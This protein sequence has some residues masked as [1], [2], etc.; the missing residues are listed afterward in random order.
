MPKLIRN[1][2]S[3][4]Q[5]LEEWQYR[6][7]ERLGILCGAGKPEPWMEKMAEREA[8]AAVAQLVKSRPSQESFDII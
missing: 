4:T 1:G 2:W 3:V 8:E 5:L 6:Y 7:E